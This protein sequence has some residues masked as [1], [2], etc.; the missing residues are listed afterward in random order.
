MTS[1]PISNEN[2]KVGY[3]SETEGYIKD[4]TVAEA[5]S[6]E[7]LNPETVFVFVNGDGKVKYLDIDGVN[8]LTP[9]DLLRAD[10]CDVGPQPCPPP[11][12]KFFGGGGI[13]AEA[14]P[15]VDSQGNLL[16]ADVVNGGFGYKT[17][18]FVTVVDPCKNGNGAVL[19]TEIRNGAVVRV[20]VNETGTGYLPPKATSPQYPAILQISEVR[21]NNPGINYDPS[22]DQIVIEPA[23]G[24]QLSYTTA[25]FGKVS[26]VSVLRGGNF[27]ELPTIRMKTRTGVNASFT[28]V[29]DVIRDPV[30]VEPVATDI[31]QVFDLVGLNVNGYVGGKAYYGNVY[32]VNGVKL[33]GTSAQSGTNIR[34]FETR[35][36]SISGESVPVARTVRNE[37]DIQT[38][39][40]TTQTITAEPE[41]VEPSTFTTTP[42]PT[43]TS[44]PTPA[45]TVDPTPSPSPSPAPYTPPDTGGGGGGGYGY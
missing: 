31:V 29:F 45:P 3:I 14:N 38:P 36:A 19:K 25:P 24:T 34:V 21:V 28:P 9:T 18:P 5:N 35:A 12:L 23:N 11:T 43:V 44:D 40:V 4:K 10:P 39:T 7:A 2:I 32:F 22:V 17:P 1:S 33:A 15:V 41:V 27:T 42:L 6:Y 20:I 8:K 26:G 37:E 13:G 30:P 16:A